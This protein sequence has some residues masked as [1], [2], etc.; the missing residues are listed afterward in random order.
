MPMVLRPDTEAPPQRPGR[1]QILDE[2]VSVDAR[3]VHLEMM[4][5]R[6]AWLGVDCVDGSHYRLCIWVDGKHKLRFGGELD[7]KEG[8]KP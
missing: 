4:G 6:E 7:G 1:L 8:P 5:D 3:T 2:A